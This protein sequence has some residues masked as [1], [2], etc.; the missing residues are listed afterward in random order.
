MPMEW[1]GHPLWVTGYD[2]DAAKPCYWYVYKRAEEIPEDYHTRQ[3][4][5]KPTAGD[6]EYRPPAGGHRV[7]HG[8]ARGANDTIGAGPSAPRLPPT[9]ALKGRCRGG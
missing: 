7:A 8:A 5:S 3:G 1:G 4:F 2:P 6:G 9:W